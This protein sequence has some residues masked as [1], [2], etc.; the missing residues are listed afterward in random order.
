MKIK[1]S[2]AMILAAAMVV[3]LTACGTRSSATGSK[4]DYMIAMVTDTG[5]VNDQSFN[6]SAWE[7]LK[8]LR[9]KDNIRV[10]YIESK[11]VSDFVTNL[12]VLADNGAKLL[13][14]I[15]FATVDA[16]TEAAEVNPELNYAVVDNAFSDPIP[17]NVTGVTFRAQE[18]SFL[19]GYIAAAVSKT[20]QVG[21]IGG[22]ENPII[23]Q[24]QYGYEGGVA[25][26]SKVL[27]KKVTVS[28]QYAES[29]ADAA[30]GKAIANKM[31]SDGCDVVYHAAGNTG[32]GMIEA[33]KEA[34]KWAIGVD[35]DQSY[36]APDNVLTSSLK[37]VD[38]GVIK[39][40]ESYMA[41]ESIGGKNVSYGLSEDAVGIPEEHPNYSDEIYNAA[42]KIKDEIKNGSITPPGT[43]GE[44][45]TYVAGL[46]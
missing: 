4:Y 13:W 9:D 42:M 10:N 2:A 14:A 24:F 32:Q 26:A 11:Q 34:G 6:Q 20:G 36:L 25:Y 7:G 17:A 38:A 21:F 18:S 31:F 45:N 3:C 43:E 33:A 15:G 8:Q 22:I 5:G 19:V 23:Y 16:V 12:D 1:Q 40:S 29:F 27:G 35:R 30:K 28:A 46:G 41:G 37:N 44:Y 39:L